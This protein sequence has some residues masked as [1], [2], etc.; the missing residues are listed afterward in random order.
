MTDEGGVS[1]PD[2]VVG[3]AARA[4]ELRAELDRA[5]HLYYVEQAPE[6]SDAEYDALFRELQGIEERFPDLLTADSPTQRV[7]APPSGEFAEVVHTLPM[8]SL[9][10]VVDREELE[11]W[12]RRASEHVE[13]EEFEY[14]CELKIDGLAI[15]CTYE[16]GV[17]ARAAT[18]GDGFRG[19][20]VTANVRT[21][22]S[23]PLRLDGDDV[24][25]TVELRGEVY[26]PL[27]AFEQMNREREEK[28]LPLYVNPRNT[29]SGALRQLD[30]RV[31]ASRPL[32]MVF[33][34]VGHVD[35]V[36][37]DSHWET[38][39]SIRRWGGKVNE[40]TRR[41][42]DIESVEA[43]YQEA[44]AARGDLEFGIDG[45]VVKID[46]IALQTRLGVSGR[47]PRWATAYKFPAERARTR[48]ISIGVNVGRTGS[49]NPFA[50]LEPVV[51]G[52]V[53]V[54]RA[55]LHNAQD[56]NEK[57]IRE[58]IDVIVQRA[59]DVIPQVV[60]P[61]EALTAEQEADEYRLPEECPV[62]A[63][64]TV[65]PEDQAMTLCVNS[66][67]PAQFERLLQHFA[68]RGAMDIEG[69]GERVS[70]DLARNGLVKDLAEVFSL[71]PKRDALLELEKMGEKRVDN[72]LEA[73]ESAK[74]R[75]LPRLL[76][77]L[78]IIGVG[79]EVAEWLSRRFR[80]LTGIEEGAKKEELIEI[81]GIGPV[82]AETISAWVSNPINRDLL[83]RL[84]AAGVDPVD[85]TPAPPADHPFAG[86]TLV[87][88]GRLETMSRAEAQTAIKSN[89]GK[90]SSSVSRKTD[91]LVAGEDAGSKHA[92]AVRLGVPVLDEEQFV[93][94]LNGEVVDMEA[95]TSDG[96]DD[97]AAS[98]QAGLGL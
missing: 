76:F 18:R 75:P 41:V 42:S 34:S 47:D 46:S 97:P 53:T 29:A 35:G 5:N 17:L 21:I 91:F 81:D 72:L 67:C 43:A 79:A 8:L 26:F 58:N 14:V 25:A 62:C 52:G 88:T 89:G 87:V 84:R 38:L 60:G 24:P 31:T 6:I 1:I 92:T 12:K 36:V 23:V 16:N 65:E 9:S 2:D 30:S 55:T 28:G 74:T 32:D 98:S 69:L 70:Q 20:D 7:G 45:M 15:S 83:G 4:G 11:A 27:P 93:R 86:K 61:A 82:L 13:I 44:L 49:L 48:L 51:V 10:N 85:E 80:S 96:Q 94:V 68:S 54:S 95:L 3:A 37:S 56:I 66:S 22:R 71:R 63:E 39:Q 64:P 59:G 90:A 77:G 50:V 78:G 57:G 19:E 33:Y 40:W 73:I